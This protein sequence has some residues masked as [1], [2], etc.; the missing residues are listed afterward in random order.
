MAKVTAFV[1]HLPRLSA[2]QYATVLDWTERRCVDSRIATGAHSKDDLYAVLL[3]A[4]DERNLKNLLC[5]NFKNWNILKPTYQRGWFEAL[6]VDEYLA[7]AGPSEGLLQLV[8]QTIQSALERAAERL[9]LLRHRRELG[10]AQ[11]ESITA[12]N[13]KACVASAWGALAAP[14]RLRKENEH[15][16]Q[17]AER[18][19]QLEAE[20][21]QRE[22]DEDEARQKQKET[23]WDAK[24]ARLSRELR[25]RTGIYGHMPHNMENIEALDDI[26]FAKALLRATE[27]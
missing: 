17:F 23:E 5:T 24:R 22:E 18:Q 15:R 6:T 11:L 9:N 13:S 8:R 2:M 12:K 26:A 25:D 3:E 10:M 19:R 7:A 16:S 20:N 1:V 4:R 27:Q 14:V 21:R